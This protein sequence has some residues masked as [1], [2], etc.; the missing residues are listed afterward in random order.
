MTRM[1]MT[2]IPRIA[3]ATMVF[4]AV[5]A[6][7]A[8]AQ[9]LAVSAS[10]AKTV[11]LSD[12][13]GDNQFIWS[14]DAPLEDI[15]GTAEG[16]SGTLRIDPS[17]PAS[18]SGTISAKVSTM[19]SGNGTRDQ[20]LRSS[21]WLDAKKHDDIT[22]KISSIKNVSV[23]GNKMSGTAVGT[24]TL[25]GVSKTMSVPFTLTYIDASAAT[26]KRAPGDLVMITASFDVRLADFNVQGAK[27]LVGSKVAETI[28]VEAKLFG[29]TGL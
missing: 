21:Q 26:R 18:I 4:V 13:V 29:S 23:S 8:Q 2:L 9:R 27:D 25:H 24:F 16:V 19:K 3:F 28:Q 15:R 11:T 12:K 17:N 10:G 5:A 6:T 7:G 20:H 22:F 1:N 14:S